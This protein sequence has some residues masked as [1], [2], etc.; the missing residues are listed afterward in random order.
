MFDTVIGCMLCALSTTERL[1]R[2]WDT[3]LFQVM[4]VVKPIFINHIA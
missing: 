3:L 4:C 2:S 1:L